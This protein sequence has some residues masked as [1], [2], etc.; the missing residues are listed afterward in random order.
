MLVNMDFF[1]QFH[2]RH[3]SHFFNLFCSFVSCEINFFQ[4]PAPFAICMN[5][6]TGVGMKNKQGKRYLSFISGG[7]KIGTFGQ[8]FTLFISRQN[9]GFSQANLYA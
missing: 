9:V 1:I 4:R 6:F 5:N 3:F 7:G 2:K 8:T